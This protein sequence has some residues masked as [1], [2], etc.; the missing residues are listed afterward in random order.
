MK[1]SYQVEALTDTALQYITLFQN[2]TENIF[3]IWFAIIRSDLNAAR[4][5]VKNICPDIYFEERYL[6]QINRIRSNKCKTESYNYVGT[7]Y[8]R[9]S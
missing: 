3:Q 8:E 9:Y 4:C 2:I 5:A 6:Q 1:Q 7:I